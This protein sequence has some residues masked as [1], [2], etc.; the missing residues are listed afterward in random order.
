MSLEDP[1]VE[2][3]GSSLRMPR[4]TRRF[5]VLY[6][7]LGLSRVLEYVQLGLLDPSRVITMKVRKGPVQG[8]RRARAVPCGGFVAK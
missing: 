8:L 4:T 1:N 6:T 7:Q 2:G 5:E 3:R